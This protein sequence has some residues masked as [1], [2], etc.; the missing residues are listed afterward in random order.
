M[1]C[2]YFYCFLH[3]LPFG[4]LLMPSH[5]SVLQSPS[6]PALIC[7]VS[8]MTCLL[9]A[10]YALQ[11]LPSVLLPPA[12]P[13]F[14]TMLPAWPAVCSATCFIT[15]LLFCCLMYFLHSVLLPHVWLTMYFVASCMTYHLFCCLLND[16]PTLCCLLHNLLSVLLPNA[17]PSVY[18]T[19]S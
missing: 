14:Y 1:T 4:Q 8:C 11:C 9:K 12:R 19:A 7:A 6:W 3:D 5:P 15:Y 2:P 10:A 16:L 17:S 18:S 13:A